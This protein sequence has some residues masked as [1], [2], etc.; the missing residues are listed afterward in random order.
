MVEV[1]FQAYKADVTAP[2]PGTYVVVIDYY[3][4]L[5]EIFP[6]D[7]EVTTHNYK[8]RGGITFHHCPYRYGIC[9]ATCAD[10]N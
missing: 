4:L 2:N 6:V 10:M 9:F 3:N 5:E 8:H 7:V 1:L